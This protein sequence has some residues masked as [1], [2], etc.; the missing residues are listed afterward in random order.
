MP[1]KKAAFIYQKCRLSGCSSTQTFTQ[2]STL[3]KH[4]A[5]KHGYSE[6]EIEDYML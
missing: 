5:E 6:D 1:G 3:K 2:A 4:L